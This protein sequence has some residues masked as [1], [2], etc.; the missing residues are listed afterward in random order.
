[1]PAI[2]AWGTALLL[3]CAFLIV[4]LSI[5]VGE[6][7]GPGSWWFVAMALLFG[8][9]VAALVGKRRE[10]PWKPLIGSARRLCWLLP[11]MALVGSLDSAMISGHEMVAVIVAAV[12]GGINWIGLSQGESKDA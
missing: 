6:E 7:F 5:L 10:R 1:M 9:L 2:L 8:V 3:D 12:L 11:V 4:A